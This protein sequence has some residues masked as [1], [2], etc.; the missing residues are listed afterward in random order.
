MKKLLLFV[1]TLLVSLFWFANADDVTTHFEVEWSKTVWVW[2]EVDITTIIVLNWDGEGFDFEIYSPVGSPIDPVEGGMIDT[3][4]IISNCDNYDDEIPASSQTSFTLTWQSERCSFELTLTYEI[5][6]VWENT[7]RLFRDWTSRD[8]ISITWTEDVA[9]DSAFT[10][11]FE[12][13]WDVTAVRVY[14]TT[15]FDSDTL[16]ENE[17]TIWGGDYDIDSLSW[18]NWTIEFIDFNLEQDLSWDSTFLVEQGSYLSWG[19]DFV[20]SSVTASDG[21]FPILDIQQGGDNFDNEGETNFEDEVEISLDM[22]EDW[23]FYWTWLDIWEDIEKDDLVDSG[24]N[25][26]YELD[27]TI[28]LIIEESQEFFVVWEDIAWNISDMKTHT[29]DNRYELTVETDGN[30][31]VEVNWDNNT[32]TVDD[33]D[34]FEIE[35]DTEVTLEA[36]GDNDYEF[37]SWDWD[38]CEDEWDECTFD[39]PSEDITVTANFEEDDEDDDDEEDDDDDDDDDTRRRWWWGWG[40][41]GFIRTDDEDEEEEVDEEEEE[42]EDDPEEDDI[43]EEELDDPDVD[44][45]ISQQIEKDQQWKI[46]QRWTTVAD[47]ESSLKEKAPSNLEPT[48]EQVVDLF[49]EENREIYQKSL[50]SDQLFVNKEN[51]F[52]NFRKTF[53][54]VLEY[55]SQRTPELAQ[56]VRDYFEEYENQ[57][58]E[59][60][61]LIESYIQEN[62]ISEL[63]IY[64]YQ[65]V[66]EDL[67][68]AI[69]LLQE[70]I[71]DKITRLYE[72]NQVTSQQLDEYVEVYNEFIWNIVVFNL[73]RSSFARE[74]ALAMVED[75]VYYYEME[76]LEQ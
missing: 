12:W 47:V 20:E 16:D 56:E 50:V 26:E 13:D 1:F 70:L 75:F 61:Q 67:N 62:Y 10:K 72:N 30:W 29:Y 38:R 31:E 2:S 41:W 64:V 74:N 66:D 6:N 15:W 32:E 11:D 71:F 51:I 24:E 9:L 40:G 35:Y 18:D 65:A 54:K 68:Q 42:P 43:D 37:D 53:E 22:T 69:V 5:D 57:R 52:Y 36:E 59:A 76:V 3:W 60:R 17:Y 28:T 44:Q 23:Y 63:D 46:T 8:N 21:I 55:R 19:T 4:D 73:E 39:M 27:D 58:Q 49:E 48:M 14:F 7:F 45:D 25:L 34:D 33:S